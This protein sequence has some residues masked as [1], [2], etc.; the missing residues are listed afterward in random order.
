MSIKEL[1]I[2]ILTKSEEI[3]LNV[4]GESPDS[5]SEI[6]E[7]DANANGESQFQ[8]KEG[9]FY[10][11]KISNKN[12]RLKSEFKDIVKQSIYDPSTGRISPNIYVGTLNLEISN[13]ENQERYQVRLEVTSVKTGYRDD[14]R[15]ML[16]EI[17]EKC[18][19][20]LMENT[21]PVIQNFETDFSRDPKTLY[22]Q[23]AFLKS[24]LDS[25]EFNDSVIKIISNPITRWKEIEVDK[26]I[27]NIKRLDSKSLRQIAGSS[28]Q[29]DLPHDHYLK[30]RLHTIPV[31]L[32]IREK[33][34]TVDTPENRFIK[35]VLNS[36]L[37]LSGILRVKLR[38]DSRNK[39]DAIRSE[40]MLEQFLSHPI[41]KEISYPDTLPLNSP[42]LQ[43]KEGYREILKVWFM[44]NLAAKL[45]WPGGEDVYDAG[46]RDVAVL[47]EY[48]LFFKL[49][50]IIK[51]V[52]KINP[53]ST[54]SLIT[55]TED[56]LGLRLKQGSHVA[57]RG[58]YNGI[59][60]KL[61]VEFS[62]NR[63]FSGEMDYPNGGS[64][65]KNMRPD[66]TLTIWPYDI[67]SQ[68][69]AE[70]QELIVHIHF[71]AKYKIE[72]FNNILGKDINLDEEKSDQ[73]KGKYK[74]ADLLKMHSYRDAIRRTGGA[75]ILYPGKIKYN[76]FG[77]HEIIPGLG[78]FPIRPSKT[79]TGEGELKG[80]FKDVV[81]HFLNRAS[82]RE[83]VAFG[84]YNVYKNEESG[85]LKELLPETIGP[86]RGLL[87]DETFVLV[88][89]YKSPEHLNWIT[90][91]KLYN[92][93]TDS[94][95]GSISISSKEAGAKYL[96]LHTFDE[97]KT[98]RLFKLKDGGPKI[99]SKDDLIKIS[100]PNPQHNYYLV[101][102]LEDKLEKELEGKEWN[103]LGMTSFSKSKE[104]AIPF[105]VSLTKLMKVIIK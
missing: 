105:S 72:D 86:N 26:D 8:I 60:R 56:G 91:N 69:E 4:Y 51:D 19:D 22:Q 27:R 79:E 62:Y 39:L 30:G 100:Y 76:K 55:K 43:R 71:D 87:P 29:T 25:V 12:F 68:Q 7:A 9:H 20:L 32:K 93:R 44:F 89:F 15:N 63:T 58:I 64:W 59:S 48:W 85:N 57:I 45:I 50:D 75:Y 17:T 82:Q 101:F 38:D 94:D 97:T 21:S 24:I 13:L 54:E 3:F 70:S 104:S 96:L 47:Y 10:E 35:Y 61:N 78:A 16:S 102:E 1:H 88:A 67:L 53:E 28:N 99:Y 41:F 46:K 42:V 18:T 103:I 83:K 98:G 90:V 33:S 84:T 92:A 14:Y 95:R 31:R 5:V 34:E 49:L 6:P 73:S 65:T 36:F 80:F 11:Y 81:Q 74:R 40:E 2:P 66:Y 52:F 23:F 77:F 37:A